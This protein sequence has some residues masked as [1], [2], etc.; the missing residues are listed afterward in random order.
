MTVKASTPPNKGVIVPAVV[1]V[2]AGFGAHEFAAR[3]ATARAGVDA[4]RRMPR[5]MRRLVRPALRVGG[6]GRA[7]RA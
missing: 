6:F 2:F 1:C 7:V 4:S 3:I 5:V